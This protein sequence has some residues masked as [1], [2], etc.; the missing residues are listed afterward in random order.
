MQ[1][2]Q[3]DNMQDNIQDNMQV[4]LFRY[5]KQDNHQVI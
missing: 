3:Q 4:I 1:D 5:R 2:N